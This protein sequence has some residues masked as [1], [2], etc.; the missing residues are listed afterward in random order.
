M[1]RVRK[2]NN[3]RKK[4]K[5]DPLERGPTVKSKNIRR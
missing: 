1:A 3:E 2:N 5:K 4:K